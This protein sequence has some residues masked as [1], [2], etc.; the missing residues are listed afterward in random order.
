MD[1]AGLLTHAAEQLVCL[2]KLGERQRWTSDPP[3]ETRNVWRKRSSVP[4]GLRGRQ[5]GNG[6]TLRLSYR[7]FLFHIK[8][9]RRLVI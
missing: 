5:L 8:S 3:G 7:P 6:G 4:P 9:D 1:E 2:K